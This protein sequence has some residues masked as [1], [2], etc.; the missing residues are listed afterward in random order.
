MSVGRVVLGAA[1]AVFVWAGSGCSTDAPTQGHSVSRSQLSAEI[2]RQLSSLEGMPLSERG[3]AR[4]KLDDPI[5][6]SGTPKQKQRY[7]ELM[8]GAPVPAR[9]L[10]PARG[11]GRTGP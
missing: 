6:K 4:F 10:V 1:L 11:S 2:D 3:F 8:K 7:A 5:A 9:L